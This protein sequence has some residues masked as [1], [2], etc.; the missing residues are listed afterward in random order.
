MPEPV[1]AFI[2]IPKTGGQTLCH[3]FCKHLVLHETFIHLG[4]MGRNDAD[5]RGLAPWEERPVEERQK[6][7]VVLGH[8]VTNDLASLLPGRPI[9]WAVFLRDPA[10]LLVSNYNFDMSVRASAGDD[11]IG[12]DAWYAQKPRDFQTWWLLARFL[13][14]LPPQA[15][16]VQRAAMADQLLQQVEWV[17]DTRRLDADAVPILEAIGVP[18]ELERRNQTGLDF[19]RLLALDD[20]LRDRL[21]R[22]NPFDLALYHRWCVQREALAARSA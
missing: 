16:G 22:E 2:H 19:T 1:F 14:V 9:R 20:A 11:P 5:E 10:E 17:G 8:G 4:R 7:R 6:A 15:T 13:R 18:L 21:S 12:F 3:H